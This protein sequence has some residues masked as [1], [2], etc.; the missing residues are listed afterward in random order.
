M[1]IQKQKPIYAAYC[2]MCGA[3]NPIIIDEETALSE[4]GQANEQ[5]D[6]LGFS[7][8]GIRVTSVS[9]CERGQISILVCPLCLRALV[10]A[11]IHPIY[12]THESDGERKL[13]DELSRFI[14]EEIKARIDESIGK[15]KQLARQDDTT[16][17]PKG[18]IGLPATTV[19]K[20]QSVA[21]EQGSHGPEEQAALRRL[22]SQEGTIE[23]IGLLR[24]IATLAKINLPAEAQL[25]DLD[26]VHEEL[27]KNA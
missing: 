7:L 4:A 17:M 13:W 5:A 20:L 26:S 12:P 22:L 11:I 2:D 19:A 16:H 10:A 8:V 14:P 15:I 18:T 24:A 25:R 21:M 23:D 27:R 3:E 9:R 6:K 1:I